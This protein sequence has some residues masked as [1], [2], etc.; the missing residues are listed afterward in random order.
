[1]NKL[2]QMWPGIEPR[3]HKYE[4]DALAITANLALDYQNEI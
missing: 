1:M 2:D 4:Q 3:L